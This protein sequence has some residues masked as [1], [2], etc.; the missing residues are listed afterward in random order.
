MKNIRETLAKEMKDKGFRE[1]YE[2]YRN[3]YLIGESVRKLRRI[4]G[5]TQK[6]LAE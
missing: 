6:D 1:A 3:S 5:M 2:H 4:A